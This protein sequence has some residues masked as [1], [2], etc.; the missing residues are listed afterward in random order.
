MFSTDP[1]ICGSDLGSRVGT[2]FP[3][4]A[5][6][7]KSAR[8]FRVA[9]QW[10]QNPPPHTHTNTRTHARTRHS[11]QAGINGFAAADVR[12]DSQQSGNSSPL[13]RET[14]S[15][16]KYVLQIAS[17]HDKPKAILPFF[18]LRPLTLDISMGDAHYC[19]RQSGDMPR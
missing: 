5:L 6:R 7:A 3:R 14:S 11:L 9:D 17:M 12:G 18:L 16:I 4:G 1:W 8:Y 2:S 19:P 10:W 13:M 15:S